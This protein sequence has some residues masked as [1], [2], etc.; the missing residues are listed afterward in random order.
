MKDSFPPQELH[1]DTSSPLIERKSK[2]P[3]SEPVTLLAGA[4]IGEVHQSCSMTLSDVIGPFGEVALPGSEKI[5]HYRALLM[6][7]LFCFCDAFG[8]P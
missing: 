1:D 8:P 2:V 3:A 6:R 5:L 4:G 7:G